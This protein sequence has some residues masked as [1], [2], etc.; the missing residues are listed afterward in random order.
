MLTS[1]SGNDRGRVTKL[2]AIPGTLTPP[3]NFDTLAQLIGRPM[4][5]FDWMRTCPNSSVDDIAQML[6]QRLAHTGSEVILVGH[7]TG[8]VIAALAAC[9]LSPPPR[10]LVL[11]NS[12]P[13][14][15]RHTLIREMLMTLRGLDAASTKWDDFARANV[16]TRNDGKDLRWIQE[17]V[18]YSKEVGGESAATALASQ[19]ALDLR[20]LPS[21]DIP[22]LVIHGMEDSKR[23]VSDA[24]EWNRVF[25]QCQISIIPQAGHTPH[26]ESPMEVSDL[27]LSFMRLLGDPDEIRGAR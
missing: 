15:H 5:V 24:Q 17:M 26:L 7:S 4:E 14:M 23:S 1:V 16:A 18:A 25:N 10:G 8:A 12:G 13:H 11:I 3:S 27:I 21:A 20:Q 6:S 2:L 9:R 19:H 22:V